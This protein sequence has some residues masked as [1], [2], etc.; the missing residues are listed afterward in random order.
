M[1]EIINPLINLKREQ[2]FFILSEKV[3]IF[4]STD[5]SVKQAFESY[6]RLI[7][8]NFNFSLSD[9]EIIDFLDLMDNELNKL[10]KAIN[11]KF[12]FTCRLNEIY[13][14]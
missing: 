6:K 3:S 11:I 9:N 10:A 12:P 5:N 2:L 8:I 4:P 14:P 13:N 7:K 1:F